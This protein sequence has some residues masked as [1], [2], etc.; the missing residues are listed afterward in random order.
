MTPGTGTGLGTN[1]GRALAVI[2]SEWSDGSPATSRLVSLAVSRHEVDGTVID[3]HWLINPLTRISD[4]ATSVHGIRNEDVAD[5]P[6]FGQIGDEIAYTLGDCDIAGYGV[7]GDIE[8]LEKELSQAG[9]DWSPTGAAI[10]DGLR[11][12]QV[13]EERK[14]EDAYRRFVG[15]LPEGGAAHDAR[16]DVEM[17]TAVI[18]ALRGSRTMEEIHAETNEDIVDVAGKFRRD[19]GKRIVFAFGP[20]RGAVAT[21]HPDFLTWMINKDFPRSTR[22]IAKSLRDEAEAAEPPMEEHG[23]EEEEPRELPVGQGA[24][25]PF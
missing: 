22:E 10:I 5:S 13:L 20:Y 18:A 7:R 8:L 21:D 14:L 3:H 11:M 19:Q 6:H 12:W 25:P 1:L 2:D 24:E 4:E 16:Y 17:T 23:P 15:T 9:V